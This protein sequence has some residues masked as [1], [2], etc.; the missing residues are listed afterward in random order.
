MADSRRPGD[1]IRPRPPNGGLRPFLVS[2]DIV[3]EHPLRSRCGHSAPA[4]RLVL[5]ATSGHSGTSELAPGAIA[6]SPHSLTESFF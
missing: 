3:V 1:K 2:R 5:S 4:I 6:I